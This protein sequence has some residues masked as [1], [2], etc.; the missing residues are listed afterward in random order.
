LTLPPPNQPPVA[1][2]D[3]V[4]VEKNGSITVDAQHGVLSNDTDPDGDALS[5][6]AVNGVANNVGH[7]I[8]G[9]F[10]K[11]TLNANGSFEYSANSKPGAL[12][13][14][15]VPQDLFSYTASDGHGGTSTNTLAVT[16]YGPDQSYAQATENSPTLAGGNGKDVL[17]GAAGNDVLN[18]GNGADWL[19][20]GSGHDVMTGGNGPDVFVFNPGFGH[21][22]ITD[23]RPTTDTIQMNHAVFSGFAAVE[24]AA[25]QV[26]ADVVI[27]LDSSSTLTL[28]HV[29]LSALHASDFH[30]V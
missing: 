29:A 24:S 26:G 21:D 4:G 23:F 7:S 13:A 30:F 2:S 28:D 20:A 1:H 9:A 14:N 11:L 12:P 5:V 19:I 15:E 25:H 16:L 8:D 6:T 3:F 17:V 27:S 10:G 18:G 22:E